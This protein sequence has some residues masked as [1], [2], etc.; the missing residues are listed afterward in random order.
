MCEKLCSSVLTTLKICVNTRLGYSS[1][2]LGVPK[3]VVQH[4][5]M[6]SIFPTPVPYQKILVVY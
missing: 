5:Y 3:Q 2:L 6:L 1:A 4:Q